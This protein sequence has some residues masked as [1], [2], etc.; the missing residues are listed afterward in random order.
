MSNLTI[1]I[2]IVCLSI[3]FGGALLGGLAI[4]Y[5]ALEALSQEDVCQ[6][7]EDHVVTL[8]REVVYW[9]TQAERIHS[10]MVSGLDHHIDICF[11]TEHPPFKPSSSLFDQDKE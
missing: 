5:K 8:E 7:L 3:I 11:C 2:I 4:G 10:E 1:N 9:M 6:Y